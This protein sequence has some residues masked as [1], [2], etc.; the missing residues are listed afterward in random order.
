LEEEEDRQWKEEER[1]NEVL[2][3]VRGGLSHP[4]QF[5]QC[6]HHHEGS[7]SIFASLAHA[8]PTWPFHFRWFSQTSTGGG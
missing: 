8:H 5:Y 6:P 1:L 2:K 4:V 7:S 3:F